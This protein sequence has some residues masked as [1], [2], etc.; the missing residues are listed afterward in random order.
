[1][2]SDYNKDNSF[3]AVIN[4]I[5]FNFKTSFHH[6]KNNMGFVRSVGNVISTTD[7]TTGCVKTNT[8]CQHVFAPNCWC[9]TTYLPNVV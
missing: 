2:N 6:D 3:K 1:M 4:R 7:D 9:R 5:F 8:W